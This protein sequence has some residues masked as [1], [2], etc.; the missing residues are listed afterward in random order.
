MIAYRHDDYA[1]EFRRRNP[2]DWQRVV[3]FARGQGPPPERPHQ[4]EIHPSLEG[5]PPCRMRC[6]DCHGQFMRRAD[7]LPWGVY[8]DLLDDLW[9][10]GVPSLVLSGAYSDPT[11]N[12]GLLLRIL[13]RT[14]GTWGV[15][16]H[17]YGYG[18][19]RELREAIVRAAQE[20][21]T[22]ESYVTIS[23]VTTNSYVYQRMCHPPPPALDSLDREQENLEEFFNLVERS[24]SNLTVRINC[25]VTQINGDPRHL[26]ELLRW[27]DDTPDRVTLRFTSDFV[28]SHSTPEFRSRFLDDVYMSPGIARQSLHTAVDLARFTRLDRISFRDPEQVVYGGTRCYNSLLFSAVSTGGLVFPCQGIAGRFSESS[29]GD[30]RQERFPE[31]WGRFVRG[32][33]NEID[34]DCP[35]CVGPCERHINAALAEEVKR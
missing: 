32:R 11:V 29:Y 14:G 27:F 31:V 8:E 20:D 12:E 22:K 33:W 30:L 5:E 7:G 1:G 13:G 19:D 21:S 3:A 26:A 25:R 9:K 23:K 18:L 17:C 16:L 34:A 24:R 35:R 2:Q 15:K 6:V 28:P 4:V 10:M